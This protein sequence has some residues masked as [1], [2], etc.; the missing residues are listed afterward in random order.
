LDAQADL[1]QAGERVTTQR[2]NMLRAVRFER[3]E[4]IPVRCHISAAC[5]HH[6]PHDAL[7]ERMADHPLLFPGYERPVLLQAPEPAPWRRAGRPY[8]DSWGC[9]WETQEHG[10]TGAVS[11][12]P[13]ASWEGWESFEPPNPDTASGWGPVDWTQI[14]RDLARARSEGRMVGGSLR[15]GHTFLTLI[16]LCGYEQVILGMAD[17]DPRL[18]RLLE[19]V[20]AFNQGIVKRYL[21]LGVEWMGYPE[22][23]GMQRGPLLSPGQFRTYIR[24]VY[25]RLMARALE[26]GCIVHMHSDGDV[27]AL[28]DDLLLSGVQ[29]INVQD[30]VN[31]IDWIRD[32]LKG[33]ICIDLD[34]DR[35]QVTRFGTPVQI[36]ALIRREVA[37]LGD[38]QGGL[39]L[40]CG[41][42]P[43]IPLE[44]MGALMDAL[45]RYSTYYS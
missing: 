20:E 13:L 17:G 25:E 39:M 23:L 2:E 42:Y 1:L 26:D 37:E 14:E 9:V 40:T 16:Y 4:V 8:V 18:V 21:D 10:L 3:P 12:H 15:H 31:G 45:T 34:V 7:V 6:Y 35:Q 38:K 24:P 44:N 30:L 36:D 11:R 27:R 5:W 29:V 19:M 41:I 32:R 33:R 22:D 28:A 43:G